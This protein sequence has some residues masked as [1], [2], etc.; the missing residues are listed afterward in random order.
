[1]N[2]NDISK[3]EYL[4][5]A[6]V[7]AYLNISQGKAYE[8]THRKDFPC[9]HFGGSIRI[10]RDLFLQWV[11]DKTYVPAQMGGVA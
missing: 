5:V 9:C 6:Q 1:M 7:K 8:L 10:P 2:I 3:H 11:K 4:T